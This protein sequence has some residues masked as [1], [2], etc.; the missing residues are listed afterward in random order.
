M[1]NTGYDE[2]CDWWS[3]GVIMF[4][5]LVGYPPFC[6]ETSQE[7]Y[8]K[9]I[10][11]KQ[12]LQ[13][14]EDCSLSME[15]RDLIQQL[16]CEREKRIRSVDQAKK[17]PWFAGFD[18]DNVRKRKEVP[19]IPK[20]KDRHDT[21]YFDK[22]EEEDDDKNVSHT[23][24]RTNSRSQIDRIFT[25]FTFKSNAAFRKLSMGTW[26]RACE[27]SLKNT[28]FNFFFFLCFFDFF[29][30]NAGVEAVLSSF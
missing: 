6:S 15:G 12:T 7:T 18:W 19:I 26:Y 3:V 29:I 24:N 17:H 28:N 13:F 8:R 1:T 20:L 9:I 11:F 23:G 22:F 27:F 14:P 16:C 2:G 4:E 30:L 21:S 10:N 5:M 25:G